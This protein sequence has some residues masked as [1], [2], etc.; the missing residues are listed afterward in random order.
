M[1]CTVLTLW[2]GRTRANRQSRHSSMRTFTSGRQEQLVLG[3]LDERDYLHPADCGKTAKEIV[4]GFATLKVINEILHRHSRASEYR[5]SAHD[6]TI[7]MKHLAQLHL[8]HLLKLLRVAP[9][10]KYGL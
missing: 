9:R 5:G 6:L 7:T 3:C 1:S 8:F 4:N 2:P 10:G